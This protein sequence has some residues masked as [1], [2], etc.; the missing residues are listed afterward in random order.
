M[1]DRLEGFLLDV[2]VTGNR[3]FSAT[4]TGLFETE[5]NPEYPENDNP[6]ILSES[7]RVNSVAIASNTIAA[8]MEDKGL[9]TA[10]I[11]FGLGANWHSSPSSLKL[12]DDYAISTSFSSY[13]LLNYNG[14]ATPEFFRARTQR[15]AAGGNQS[16]DRTVILDHERPESIL[17]PVTDAA[18]A[19]VTV[20]PASDELYVVGNS[21]YRLLVSDGRE[22]ASVIN[23]GWGSP[24]ERRGIVRS[25][26][27]VVDSRAGE[28]VATAS[29]TRQLKS[30]FVLESYETISLLMRDG[31]HLLPDQGVLRTRTFPRSR[32]HE[33]T[34]ASICNDHVDL[35]GFLEVPESS[36]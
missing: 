34:F 5:F 24:A 30:G 33:D 6:L 8:A 22:F 3:V 11:F 27:F 12:I 35:V 19:G 9:R 32:R 25:R 29:E 23:L 1:H 28:M 20:G 17:K 13:N 10:P 31:I 15:E 4:T 14:D 2:A 21:N 7:G 18:V 16:Y 26:D 36:P